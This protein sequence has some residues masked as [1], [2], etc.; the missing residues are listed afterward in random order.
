M[1]LK[2]LEELVEKKKAPK[3][4][5]GNAKGPS[6]D[7]LK[8]GVA[9]KKRSRVFIFEPSYD[10]DK[11]NFVV[12]DVEN[13]EEENVASAA[14]RKSKGKMKV[15]DDWNMINNRR[16]AKGVEEMSNEGVDFNYKEN[17][18][19][20]SFVYARN[21]LLERYLSEATM[22]NQTYMDI[23]EESGM[24]VI[25]ADIGPQWPSIVREFICNLNEDIVDPSNPMFQKV[26]MRGNVFKFS[27]VLIN[28]HY[29]RQNEGITGSTLKLAD[30]IKTL[31]GNALLAWPTKGQLQASSL[32]LRYA[33]M[34]KVVIANLLPTSN[35]TNVSEVVGRM[36]SKVLSNPKLFPRGRLVIKAYEEEKQRM[37]AEIQLKKDKVI[38]MQA[39]IQA[40]NTTVPT[41]VNDPVP[42][43]DAES[44]A[45][46]PTVNDP[47]SDDPDETS[48]SH[49]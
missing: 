33:V 16:V 25:S 17:E 15:N 38:E 1:N 37:E 32:S 14:R 4:S 42:A 46:P 29:G 47:A 35:N 19:R 39:K 34:H 12:D 30:I 5:K 2:E 44:D 48:P 49:V 3:K 21:I 41:T 40:L 9:S 11:E 23:I 45:I 10:R 24:L 13:I 36:I 28:R 26:N 22:K 18:A 31:I 27:P 7:E 6:T 43:N 8:E 20:W